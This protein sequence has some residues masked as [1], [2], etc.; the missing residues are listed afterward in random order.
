MQP[1]ACSYNL[2]VKMIAFA[3]ETEVGS[4]N[5]PFLALTA[6]TLWATRSGFITLP[7]RFSL[8][9]LQK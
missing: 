6:P 1:K 2:G 4:T 9:L 5:L 8:T 3:R 7:G